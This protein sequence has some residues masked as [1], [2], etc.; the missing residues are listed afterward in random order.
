MLVCRQTV[1]TTTV[2]FT[3][4]KVVVLLQIF[5]LGWDLDL[6]IVPLAGLPSG[7][8]AQATTGRHVFWLVHHPQHSVPCLFQYEKDHLSHLQC[9]TAATA[10]AGESPLPHD[11]HAPEKWSVFDGKYKVPNQVLRRSADG[12]AS[13]RSS[14]QSY[15]WQRSP[16]RTAES[17]VC[18][19]FS[20]D[21]TVQPLPRDYYQRLLLLWNMVSST[22]GTTR[23]RT[24]TGSSCQRRAEARRQQQQRQFRTDN[25]A[26]TEDCR[27]VPRPS[28]SRVIGFHFHQ[29][30]RQQK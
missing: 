24:T 27:I 4:A 26:T 13:S 30:Q 10:T 12:S 9:T 28:S 2:Q 16:T 3:V 15:E 23:T 17:A 6:C 29:R 14:P 5:S 19:F 20:N 1:C 8:Q 22:A 11:C 18:S 7:W 21:R 25:S